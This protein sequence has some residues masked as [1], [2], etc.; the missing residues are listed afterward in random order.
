VTSTRRTGGYRGAASLVAA[1]TAWSAVL[2]VMFPASAQAAPSF[3]GQV[4]PAVQVVSVR[5]HGTTA[6]VEGWQGGLTGWNRVVGPFEG[7]IGE[8]GVAPVAIDGVPAT[9]IGVFALESVFGT[10]PP[11]GGLLPY[12]RVGGND[13]W[14]GDPRSPTYN[15]HQ[16]C[17]PG[18]CR[19]DEGESEQLAIPEYEYAVVMG[20]NAQRVPGGGGAFFMHVSGGGPTA[21]CVS[22]ERSALLAI[23]RWLAPGAV[24]AIS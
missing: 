1:I 20:V 3:D 10:G 24:I 15:T 6:T 2:L 11:P 9:P 12:Q 22:L 21:G 18:T 23:I 13:W 14:D 19:F 7:F 16:V 17:A 8:N 4:G 5:S